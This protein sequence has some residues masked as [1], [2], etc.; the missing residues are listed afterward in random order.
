[1]RVVLIGATEVAI[2]TAELLVKQGH[3][4]V[5]VDRDREKIDTVS[6]KLDCGFLHGDGS[7]PDILREAGP[8]QTDVLFCLTDSDQANIIASL[9]GRSLGFKRV[10]T[11]IHDPEF[12]TICLE[13][14]LEDTLIPART[15]SRYLADL[16][17]GLLAPELSTVIKAE[18]RFF[19]F[20]AGEEE[21]VTVHELKLPAK[22]RVVCYYRDGEF[23][24]PQEDTELRPGDQV[25]V[26]AHRESL[27]KLRDRFSPKY[28]SQPV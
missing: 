1:M 2:H 19:T 8:K 23:R 6:E 24:I 11:T 28:E 18:G 4:V 9:V 25:V 14:G 12:E 27:E 26:I 22:A 3:E 5:I 16:V 7:R 17:A 13:L 10:V 20:I 21:P 15:I